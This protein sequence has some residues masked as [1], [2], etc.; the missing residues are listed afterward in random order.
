[1]STDLIG[2]NP[3]PEAD[4][5][6]QGPQDVDALYQEGLQ[7]FQN[8]RWQEAINGFEAV[9]RLAPE[10]TEARAF[11]EE[12]RLK[13]SLDQDQ[14]KPKRTFL[15]G[16]MKRLILAAGVV[17]AV[18]VVVVAAKW[19]YQRAWRSNWSRPTGC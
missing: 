3:S 1:M 11:L 17:A 19:A 14:P 12:A 16:R 18:L 4:S 6:G 7:H 5:L 9:L 2:G 13:A 10:H 15:S 8:G